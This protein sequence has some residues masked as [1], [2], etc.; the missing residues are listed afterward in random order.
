ME[1]NRTDERLAD[2]TEK[3]SKFA[4]S[5]RNQ[6]KRQSTIDS[7][8]Q[9][10]REKAIQLQKQRKQLKQ[11]QAW[12]LKPSSPLMAHEVMVDIPHD[13]VKDWAA[14]LLPSGTRCVVRSGNG[15]TIAQANETPFLTFQS[16][17]PGGNILDK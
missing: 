14:V 12:K 4:V 6:I 10:R 11:E 13:F 5:S 16:L 7:M 15:K 9:R 17:L 2:L 1:M 8:Q 3:I